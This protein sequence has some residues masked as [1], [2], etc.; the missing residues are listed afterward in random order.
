MNLLWNSLTVFVFLSI[1]QSLLNVTFG[2]LFLGIK[3]QLYWRRIAAFC[4]VSS[5]YVD[6]FFLTLPKWA[7]LINSL[8]SFYILFRLFFRSFS[9]KTALLIFAVTFIYTIITDLAVTTAASGFISYQAVIDG[10]PAVKMMVFWPG[11]AVTAILILLMSKYKYYPAKRIRFMFQNSSGSSSLPY[12]LLLVFIQL[13]V[14]SGMYMIRFVN[15]GNEDELQIFL[16]AGMIS[17]VLVTYFMLRLLSRTSEEAVKKTEDVYVGDL[18]KMLT[19]VRGQRHDFLNHVQVMYSM[20]QLKKYNALREYM[21]ELVDEVL[22]VSKASLDL[23]QL[24]THPLAALIE[25]KYETSVLR[26]IAFLFQVDITAGSCTFHPIRNIDLVRIAGNLI[27]NAFDEVLQLP[28]CDRQVNLLITAKKGNLTLRMSNSCR[29]MTEEMKNRL[30]TPG[31]TTKQGN[32]SGLGLSIV[33]ERVRFYNGSLTV[34]T[35]G[36]SIIFTIQ[37]PYQHEQAG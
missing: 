20:L 1:P 13:I 35:E 24:Q 27:D 3:P 15:A 5:L 18:V 22:S 6:L 33:A 29:F 17:I 14:L 28:E 31:Y 4:F 9:K 11:F 37:L 7:H 32:H 10:S 25:S 19:T 16:G 8:L 2:F 21:D 26:R 30:F 23:E 12:V 34:D 36:D